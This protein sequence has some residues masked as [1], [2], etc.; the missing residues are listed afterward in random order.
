MVLLLP[1]SFTGRAAIK[2]G[3]E[4][5]IDATSRPAEGQQWFITHV[6]P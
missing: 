1:S 5:D 3:Q 2:P 4:S 6:A